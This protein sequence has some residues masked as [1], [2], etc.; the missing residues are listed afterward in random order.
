LVDYNNPKQVFDEI[1]KQQNL[2]KTLLG[3]QRSKV[4]EPILDYEEL[5][6]TI[7]V[8]YGGIT[9]CIE[10]VSFQYIGGQ[11]QSRHYNS[12]SSK[13]KK[14]LLDDDYIKVLERISAS[15]EEDEGY[16]FSTSMT[17]EEVIDSIDAL[18]KTHDLKQ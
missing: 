4:K 5:T 10:E 6:E 18:I 8:R 12:N 14:T 15:M 9:N 16:I 1:K 17:G 2:V 11:F 7:N 13:Y 3:F